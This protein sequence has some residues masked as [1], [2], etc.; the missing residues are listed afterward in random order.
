MIELLNVFSRYDETVGK[1][2]IMRLKL[3]S[4]I[5]YAV[6]FII[7]SGGFDFYRALFFADMR[8]SYFVMFFAVLL[9]LPFLKGIYFNKIFLGWFGIIIVLS[10]Y[11]VCIGKNTLMLLTKQG[12]GIL[13]SSVVFYC[14]IRINKCDVVKLFRIY[15]N[16][17]VFVGIIGFFQEL[18]YLFGW[19]AGYD[20]SYVL[21][22]WRLHLSRTGFLR[23]NSILA[24]PDNFC[25]SMMPAFFVAISSYFKS[26]FIF[27]RKW[28]SA[29]IIFTV[30]FSFSSVGYIGVIFSLFLLIYNYGK[31]RNIVLGAVG[32][33]ML[34]SFAYNNIG[35]VKMRVDDSFNVITGE[36]SLETTNLSTFALFS[37][38]LVAFESFKDSPFFGS[39]L[40]S[41]VI[42]YKR[43]IG[44]VVDVSKVRMFLNSED[45]N[46]LFLRLLSET[47]LFG[48]LCFLWFIFRFHLLK[49]NDKTNHL[50]IISNSILVMF[51]IRLIRAGHYF[52]GGFFFF[53]WI[54]YFTNKLNDKGVG[55]L[56]QMNIGRG[57]WRERVVGNESGA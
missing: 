36:T 19:R 21:P 56:K 32:I 23:I 14:L 18:N 57:C 4:F 25:Y 13:S 55:S 48:I 6:V 2:A 39:G 45:A 42:S 3:S 34:A 17:A 38:A 27:L 35:D 15:L 11:S 54:Y 50:W 22:S 33:I 12:I 37:N 5:N 16:I 1:V 53:F 10:L 7:F 31:M 26:N 47:G 49:K 43:Y 41:H 9:W 51:V 28:Q 8:F 24:E 40:G 44:E 29:F 52:D 46:S 30:L 20:F